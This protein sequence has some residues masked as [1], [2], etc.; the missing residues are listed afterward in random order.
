ME[1]YVLKLE[2]IKRIA[3][4]MMPELKDLT[5]EKRCNWLLLKREEKEET[6]HNI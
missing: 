6:N 1:K 4:K 2:K 5:Y 3:N